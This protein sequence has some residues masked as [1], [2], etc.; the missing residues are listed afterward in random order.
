M[1][2]WAGALGAICLYACMTTPAAAQ[3]GPAEP[4]LIVGVSVVD[5]EA[6]LVSPPRDILIQDGRIVSILESGVDA[7]PA[8]AAVVDAKGGFALPGLID[9]HAHIGEG[10]AGAPTPGSRER[11]LAQFLRY[12]V[13]TIFAP[14]ASG[15]GDDDLP[16]L[17]E[18][19]R[20]GELACPGIYGSGSI[21][22]APGSHPI[23]TIFDLPGDAPPAVLSRR[24]VIALAPNTDVGALIDA[25]RAIG[26]DAIKIVIEDGPPPW[27]P[28]PRLTD[29]QVG[30]L[31]QAAHRNGLPIYAHVGTAQHVATGLAAGVDGFMHSPIDL[32][33]DTTLGSMARSRTYLVATLALY[34]GLLSWAERRGEA[35]P[36][37][38]KGVD[39][40]VLEGLGQAGFLS[41]SAETRKDARAY[42]T[43][44]QRNLVRAVAAG[45]PTALGTD[46]NNPFVYPGYAVH[47]ELTLMVKAGLTPRQALQVATTGGAAFLRRQDQI[48]KI[49]VGYEADLLILKANPLADIANTRTASHV[50]S[51]GR[52]V[53]DPVTKD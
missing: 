20:A 26:V 13:T 14:G 32:L 40:A 48:G 35:D 22:T 42:L 45:V 47:E 39:G 5:L 30:A 17:R 28:K 49:A 31:V 6:G 33:P 44:A 8:G 38:L 41:A 29:A 24:G 37:A 9:V 16:G 23:S 15:A 25:K 11:A 21:I 19:C 12:G 46:T 3:P 4:L 27:Y 52:L 2:G 1:R 18:S 7:R 36:Y 34:D 51:D 50:V 53:P 10:G 43:A